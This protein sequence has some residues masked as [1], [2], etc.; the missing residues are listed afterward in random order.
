[1]TQEALAALVKTD[2]ATISRWE[3]GRAAQP[4]GGL[5]EA[6]RA[7]DYNYF[8]WLITGA[9]E[10]PPPGRF[11]RKESER[12]TARDEAGPTRRRKRGPGEA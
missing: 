5:T 7:L 12:L 3:S 1:V 2:Q 4:L 10:P 11:A 8:G 9:G 6:A